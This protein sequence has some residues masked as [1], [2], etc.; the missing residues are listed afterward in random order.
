MIHVGE[1]IAYCI[2]VFL[3]G[4]ASSIVTGAPLAVIFIVGYKCNVIFVR[5]LFTGVVPMCVD[6]R[7]GI[8][9]WRTIK[10]SS[11]IH[12]VICNFGRVA[13]TSLR[14][15]EL[16]HQ[17]CLHDGLSFTV[18]FGRKY[19][20]PT[21]VFWVVVCHVT[22][23]SSVP[24]TKNPG[25]PWYQVPVLDCIKV[26]VLFAGTRTRFRGFF[27][28]CES[29]IEVLF[30]SNFTCDIRRIVNFRFIDLSFELLLML[31]IDVAF[32]S[33]VPGNRQGFAFRHWEEFHTTGNPTGT[34]LTVPI[35]LYPSFDV[36]VVVG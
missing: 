8:V 23:N 13:M 17:I 9:L 34:L 21:G 20:I 27:H 25:V 28:L 15:V 7:H 35:V 3:Q 22:G 5:D 18:A 14:Y 4:G 32:Q 1:G 26:P 11:G 6:S 16:G 12:N 10:V 24:A 2:Q 31:R 30:T 36:L 19:H 33:A 29:R